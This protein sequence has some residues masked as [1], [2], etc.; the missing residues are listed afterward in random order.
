[1]LRGLAADPAYRGK[2]ANQLRYR[3]RP[4]GTARVGSGRGAA[5]A[6]AGYVAPSPVLGWRRDPR[7]LAAARLEAC[8]LAI[9]ALRSPSPAG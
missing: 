4:L 7:R 8:Q 1:M 3:L 2:T 9:T 6:S 5:S